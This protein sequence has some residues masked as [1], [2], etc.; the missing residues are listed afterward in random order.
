MRWM[1]AGWCALLLAACGG[2][3]AE[4]PAVALQALPRGNLD[5]RLNPA[6][7]W[8]EIDFAGR[9]VASGQ[10]LTTSVLLYNTG[11]GPLHVYELALTYE[12]PSGADEPAGPAL[13]LREVRLERGL[14]PVAGGRVPD[15]VLQPGAPPV[16]AVVAFHRYDDERPRYALLAIRSDTR[17]EAQRHQVIQVRAPPFAPTVEEPPPAEPCIQ[18]EPDE[19][20]F[21]GKMVGTSSLATVTVHSCG[22]APLEVSEVALSPDS[23]ASFAL[24][25]V[26]P[27]L[28]A[29]GE[30]VDL[31]VSFTPEL[32]CAEDAEGKPLLDHG[33]LVV[34][35]NAARVEVGLSGIGMQQGCPTAPIV[36]DEGEKVQPQT[37]LHLRGPEM[38]GCA[39]IVSWQ[40]SVKQPEGSKSVF[41]PS[42]SFPNPTF[43]ANVAG[44]YRFSLDVWTE[45]GVKSCVPGEAEV[46]V[47]GDEAIHVELLWHTPGDPDETDTYPAPGADLDLHFVHD[48]F[49]DAGPD[50]DQD[51]QP[52]G[53]FDQPYDCFWFNPHP[54]WG[55]PNPAAMDDPS[56]D[57]DDIDGAGPE[58]LNVTK[59]LN[60]RYR[61]GVHYWDDRDLGP[62]W[63]TLRV[64]V[65]ST[66][67][68][69]VSDVMLVNHDLWNAAVIDWTTGKVELV[70][71]DG[72]YW[73]TPGYTNPTFYQP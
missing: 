3:R 70:A 8:L 1:S 24:G 43:E 48:A 18:V 57:R 4:A 66:L 42:P 72:G 68:F 49:A 22:D 56:L 46:V 26:G 25:G 58:N 30:S 19:V 29:P 9:P 62:S 31:L 40:W 21:G 33:T 16:E 14:A 34:E 53:W 44:V 17:E 12:A 38:M 37:T 20:A 23:S 5:L 15:L 28:V 69:E 67:V 11:D 65:Y 55:N 47:V 6:A 51:G 10:E 36:I 27:A 41:V 64:Y 50:L 71:K 45:T 32:T 73:I 2:G 7:L 52:D 60:A 59:P 39:P 54:H 61:I 13:A 35:S 63:V